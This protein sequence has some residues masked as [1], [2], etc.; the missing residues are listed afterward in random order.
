MRIAICDDM[1]DQLELVCSL[2]NDYIRIHNIDAEIRTFSHPDHLLKYCETENA[3]LYLLDVVMPMMSGVQL[4]QEIRILDREAQIIYV[5]TAPEYAL[6]SFSVNPLNYLLKPL[7]KDKLFRTLDLAITKIR[8]DEATVTVKSKN[9]LHTILIASVVC[10]EYVNHAVIYTLTNGE[11][12]VTMTIKGSFFEYMAPILAD[13][14]FIQPHSSFVINMSRVERLSREGFTLRGGAVVPV[15][16][17]LFSAVKNT[18]MDFRLR[19]EV[20]V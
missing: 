6:D 2:V 13:K 11:T 5:T 8:A 7:K 9:G 18:Y 10:C 3:Q 4:G 17:K 20:T 16:G 1:P 19:D 15:S 14:R 12:I